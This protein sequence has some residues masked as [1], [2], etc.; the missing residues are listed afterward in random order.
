MIRIAVWL[1][2]VTVACAAALGASALPAADLRAGGGTTILGKADADLARRAL[3]C[4][5]LLVIQQFAI[6]PSHVYTYHVEGLRQGGGLYRYRL[7]KEGQPGQLRCLI[8]AS[9]GVILDGELSFDAR[10]VL[11]AWKRTM[12]EPFHLFTVPVEGGQPRQ[13]TSGD[14]HNFSG[15]WLPDGGIAFLSTRKAQFA[16]CWNSPVG[17]L[18]RMGADGGDVRRISANY[19]NDFTPSVLEDGRIIYG[20]WEYVDRPAIPIQKLWTIHPDGTMLSG[21]YGNRVLGP[22]TFIEAR[23]IPDGSGRVLSTMT[24]HN[25][26]PSGAI[27]IIDPSQGANAQA[28]ITNVTPEVG[29]GK[30]TVSSNGP[31]SGPYQSPWP[32]GH[33]FFL[34]TH[35]PRPGRFDDC[36]VQLRAFDG[37]VAM[38]LLPGRGGMAWVYAQPLRPR[39]R[40]PAIP[41]TLPEPPPPATDG[42][43]WATVYIQDVYQG[44]QPQVER[45][46]VA[47]VAVVQEIAKPVRVDPARR[48]FGFQFPIVSC[49]ATYAPKKI[50]GFAELEAD[51]S[52]HFQVPSGVPLYFLALDREGRAV[53]RMRTFTHFMPGEE[54]G[55]IGCHADRNHGTFSRSGAA[56]SR[57]PRSLTPPPWGVRNLDYCSVVQPVLDRH[58]VKCHNPLDRPAGLDLSGDRTEF[59]NVSYDL[60]ANMGEDPTGRGSKWV[61][62]IP[63]MNGQEWNILEVVPKTWGSPKSR[64]AEVI[65]AGHPD[66]KGQTRAT[67][68]TD[69]RQAIFS[70]IDCDVPYYGEGRSSHIDVKGCRQIVYD[71]QFQKVFAETVARR[72]A[73]C[74]PGGPQGIPWRVKRVTNVAQNDILLA[75]LAKAAGGRAACGKAVFADTRDANYQALLKGLQRTEEALL[76]RPR[77]DM[78]GWR[79][80]P[81]SNCSCK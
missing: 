68:S 73:A 51:G 75:P 69:E 70:W 74:H 34:V 53:Q 19:L 64:L 62:W 78:P 81:A 59:F 23:A 30:V 8:D 46:E 36:A 67:L 18:H 77:T 25:G 54:Q 39:R 27:G 22:A 37:S 6:M 48:A 5:E 31:A 15:C 12:Q 7:P 3:G 41:S 50:W 24:G 79:I 40:P 61:N 80:D 43:S 21:Y 44:L 63:T 52:A 4:D 14:H 13:L 17:V 2:R 1:V 76:A 20:R 65:L 33:G 35:Y 58:C 60:L 49:G 45:G 10:T 71:S 38:D 16:Y 55:C 26:R 42:I 47:R 28:A 72:C 57:S 29:I 56:V 9:A 32:L 66:Q 11:F